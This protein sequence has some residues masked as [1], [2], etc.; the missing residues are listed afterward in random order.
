MGATRYTID[1]ITK[2]RRGV[3]VL[4]LAQRRKWT[5]TDA[6]LRRLQRRVNEYASFALDGE[7]TTRYPEAQGRRVKIRL[8]IAHAPDRITRAFLRRIK[9]ALAEVRIGFDVDL[10]D[11]AKL[12]D[13]RTPWKERD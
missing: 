4:V 8:D 9:S 1:L 2:T 7:L 5:G 12:L 13:D 11:R 6:Q 3:F 10:D